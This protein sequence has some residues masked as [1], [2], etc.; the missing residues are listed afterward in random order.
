MSQLHSIINEYNAPET[1]F[2]VGGYIYIY[3]YDFFHIKYNNKLINIIKKKQFI[4]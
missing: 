1:K 2:I 4:Q 3:I